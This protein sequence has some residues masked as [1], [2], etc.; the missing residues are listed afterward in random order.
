MSASEIVG[1][2]NRVNWAAVLWPAIFLA[3]GIFFYQLQSNAYFT[4]VPG[5]LTD[6]RFNSVILEHLY[7][8]MR[9]EG[10]SL[11]SPAFF[12]PYHDALAL[13]DNHFGTVAIYAVLR[14]FGLGREPALAIW[15][16]IG[17]IANF[18]AA[19]YTLRKLG[20]RPL[21]AAA[22]GF[23]FAFSLPVLAQ[24]THAQF[25]YRAFVPLALL[26][27]WQWLQ[28]GRLTCL[29]W[30]AIWLAAQF[31]C[32][33]YTGIFTIYLL[34]A[35]ALAWWWLRRAGDTWRSSRAWL[36]S[37]PPLRLWGVL[38]LMV[39][40]ASAVAFLLLKYHAV[41]SGYG[42]ERPRWEILSM[43][44]RVSSW[45]ISDFSGL[46]SWVGGWVSNMPMRQEH[47]MFPGLAVLFFA[48]LGAL[49]AGRNI[50]HAALGKLA[51][52]AVASIF[53][54]TLSVHGISLYRLVLHLPG[55][56]SVRAVTRVILVLVL[57]I[58]ILV[59]IGVD[60]WVYLLSRKGTG[61]R[62][63]AVVSV[64]FLLVAEV[65][66]FYNIH[67]P[68]D[69]WHQRQQDFAR[70][71]PAAAGRDV[72]YA[73]K[74][75]DAPYLDDLDAMIYAQDHHLATVNGYSGYTPPGGGVAGPCESPE[76]FLRQYAKYSG[77]QE[78]AIDAI[79]SRI[80]MVPL[81]L[82]E[83]GR[84]VRFS[85]TIPDAQ[86]AA[87]RLDI[88]DVKV[89][90]RQVSVRLRIRNDSSADFS[91]LEVDGK[92]VRLSWRLLKRG[93]D[94]TT[95]GWD[96]RK[97][98]SFVLAPREQRDFDVEFNVEPGEYKLQFSL[99][100]E[101]VFWFHDRGMQIPSEYV[102]LK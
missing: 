71:M 9:G 52:L 91:T 47:Q 81:A 33:I 92:N 58:G 48:G 56:S 5:D 37:S 29:G 54:G 55:I 21:G 62:Y 13:S 77:A 8:W 69:R 73:D 86:A 17:G 50:E 26:A 39:A 83:G 1:R 36:S 49:V 63:G 94:E 35:A 3:A 64:L 34:A 42:F 32:A 96:A 74:S 59:G 14:W 20:L 4:A 66:F 41:S 53:V 97:D 89:S 22:G 45:L 38:A 79:R 61:W 12:Y 2:G 28:S 65:A 18:L 43:L 67:T 100:Q 90:G 98:L 85:G 87:I 44:P 7:Q 93:A 60:R 19:Y 11:W 76:D 75:A 99:V 68:I 102:T 40:S 15:L 23:V 25:A 57:P 27:F 80:I 82:C 6:A 101:M 88:L 24:Q 72:I 78:K 16:M 31:Y 95:V 70:R 30:C 51:L 84:V 10:V 46:S